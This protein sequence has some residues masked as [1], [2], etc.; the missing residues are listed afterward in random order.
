MRIKEGVPETA[1]ALRERFGKETLSRDEAAR[2]IGVS[3]R[4]LARWDVPFVNGRISVE[5]LAR[6]IVGQARRTK[7][8][9]L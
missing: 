7:W 5:V 2:A 4:T 3:I 9:N 6:I 8:K 1:A